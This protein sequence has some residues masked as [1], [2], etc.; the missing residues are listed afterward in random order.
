G[1]NNPVQLM[2]MIGLLEE[3]LGKKAVIEMKP[4]QPGDVYSTYADIDALEQAV[5]F[6]PST[7]LKDGLQKFAEWYRG[8]YQ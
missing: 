5:G 1:N 8:Y 3:A 4:M 6:K 7:N 2:D